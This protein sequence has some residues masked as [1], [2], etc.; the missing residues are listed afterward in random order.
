LA[1]TVDACFIVHFVCL[2][3]KMHLLVL[4]QDNCLDL[5]FLVQV[6]WMLEKYNSILSTPTEANKIDHFG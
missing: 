4:L 5:C 3:M 2:F 1:A 6:V